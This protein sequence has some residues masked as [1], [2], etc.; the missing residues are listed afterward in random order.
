MLTSYSESY[1]TWVFSKN[2][3]DSSLP[4]ARLL[5]FVINPETGIFEA[6]WVQSAKGTN[7]LCPKDIISW[8]EESILIADENEILE[9][10]ELPRLKKTLKKEVP[11]LNTKVFTIKTNTYL[12]IIT[13]FAFDTI[14]PRVLSITVKSGFWIFGSK[15]IIVRTRI[16][17]ITKTGIFVSENLV[18][19]ENKKKEL[20]P[21]SIKKNVPEMDMQERKE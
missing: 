17:K 20:L 18:K 1:K 5:D 7:L 14:S 13:D 15:K 21:K 4:I 12:G 10:K 16:K 6:L 2:A 9:T 3:N 19:I 8:N 11:L